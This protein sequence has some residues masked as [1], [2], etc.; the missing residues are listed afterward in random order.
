MLSVIKLAL[1]HRLWVAS[2]ECLTSKSLCSLHFGL[3]VSELLTQQK[4]VRKHIPDVNSKTECP[5]IV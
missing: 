1:Q 3:W 4:L 2:S 5:P